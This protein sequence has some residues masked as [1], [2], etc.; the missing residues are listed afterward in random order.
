MSIPTFAAV[1]AAAGLVAC[2]TAGPASAT[3]V[4]SATQ[5]LKLN[6]ESVAAGL[7]ASYDED[8]TWNVRSAGAGSAEVGD[9]TVRNGLSSLS[10]SATVGGRSGL[11]IDFG[12]AEMLLVRT[13]RL[14]NTL[15]W[16]LVYGFGMGWSIGVSS[17]GDLPGSVAGDQVFGEI[18][19]AQASV[20]FLRRTTAADG[21][22]TETDFYPSQSRSTVFGIDATQA[23]PNAGFYNFAGN[24]TVRP[25]EIVELVLTSRI[26]AVA[27]AADGAAFPGPD[28]GLSS[29]P[30]PPALAMLGA[31]LGILGATTRRRSAT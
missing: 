16:N 26:G 2:A 12:E 15:A 5:D 6:Y 27:Y 23:L 11:P 25:D 9:G 21:T 24:V 13:I 19:R 20:S 3:M 14:E 1:A 29:V 10:V 31:A 18:G 8:L 4:V 28:D 30:L 17:E 22:V 7:V